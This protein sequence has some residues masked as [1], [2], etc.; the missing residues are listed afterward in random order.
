MSEN[1]QVE[2]VDIKDIQNYERNARNHNEKQVQQLAQSITDYGFTNPPLVDENNV[3]IAGHG[4]V[5][6]AKLAGLEKIPVIRLSHLSEAKKRA[7]RIADNKLA[8]NGGGWNEELL[9]LELSELQIALD[10]LDISAT[11]FSTIEVDVLL[12][13]KPAKAKTAKEDIVPYVSDGE[14]VTKSGYIWQIG[15]HRIICGS[16]LV[17]ETYQRLMDGVLADQVLTDPPY[18]VSAVSIG[19]SGKTKHA[20]FAMAAGEMSKTEFTKFLTDCMTLCAK[21]STATAL[22]YFWQDWRHIDEIMAAGR[23]AYPLFI[24]LCV[25]SKATGGMGK[26]YRSQHELCFIFGKDKKYLDNVELGKHGRYRTN[27]WNYAGV[28]SFGAHK[29]DQKFHPT[30]KPYE[31][32]K[33][34]ILDCTP[35]GGIVLDAFLGSGTTLIAAEKAKRICYGI[36]LEPKYVD[37]AIRRFQDLFKVDA[38]HAESGKTYNEL[39]AEKLGS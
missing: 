26:L 1:L 24:N 34:A 15:L 28:N 7:Y 21:Y 14:V 29:G 17:Y 25:W 6:G 33:D 31:M 12:D 19:N 37:T 3:L 22:G 32:F 38:I 16:S 18:N 8:E 30:T 11:G 9:R 27:V 36:E 10:D 4:R 2:Y 39:L 35:R 5:L 23:T 20:D 13:E